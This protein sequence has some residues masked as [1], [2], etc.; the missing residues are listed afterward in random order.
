[1]KKQLVEI[2]F[3]G[4]RREPVV[5][6]AV[7]R[8]LW[9]PDLAGGTVIVRNLRG[10]SEGRGKGEIIIL[11]RDIAS[12]QTLASIRRRQRKRRPPVPSPRA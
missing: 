12:V 10:D 7:S 5:V 3:K 2:R 8:S 9:V 4:G 1:M 6:D 11:L